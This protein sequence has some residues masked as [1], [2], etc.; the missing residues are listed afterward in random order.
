MVT[1]VRPVP[2]ARSRQFAHP[3]VQSAWAVL[4]CGFEKVADVFEECIYE[5][6]TRF[7]KAQLD[8]YLEA[9]RTIGKLGRGAEPLLAFLEEWPSVAGSVSGD[10]EPLL[11]QVMGAIRAMQKSPNS[12]AIT[13]FLQTLA[14]VARR[15][16]SAEQLEVYIDIALNL[17]ARTSGSIHGHH[18]TFPQPR[19]AALVRAGAAPARPAVDRRPEQLDRL[20]HPQ[21]RRRI[22]NAR[23]STSASNRPTAAPWFSANATARCLPTSNVKLD[24]YLRAL[25]QDSEQL[26]PYSTLLRRPCASRFLTTIKLGMRVPDVI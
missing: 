3:Q 7:T 15:L 9:A 4:D 8:A 20:R 12:K 22:R 10:Q 1:G 23:R 26:V 25:W 17:M 16:Q 13:P 11:P 18:T 6:L 24:L 14:A 2:D 19:P 5:A 21:L